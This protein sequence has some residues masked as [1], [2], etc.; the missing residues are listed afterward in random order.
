MMTKKDYEM[1]ARVIVVLPDNTTRHEVAARFAD[2][3]ALANRMFDYNKFQKACD[4]A[5]GYNPVGEAIEFF[6]GSKAET[7]G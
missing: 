6:G 3:L 4:V 2:M 1:I 7:E 5:E